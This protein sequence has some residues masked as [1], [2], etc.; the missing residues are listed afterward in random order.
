[1]NA[2]SVYSITSQ[3][4]QTL[5]GVAENCIVI[6]NKNNS[7]AKPQKRLKKQKLGP[8]NKEIYNIKSISLP[9]VSISSL[10]LVKIMKIWC[11]VEESIII[12]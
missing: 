6:K 3:I 2:D 8:I 12:N 10:I 11:P 7:P 9:N 4:S 5:V 1:M